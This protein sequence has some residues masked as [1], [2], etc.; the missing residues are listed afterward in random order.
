MLFEKSKNII[1]VN[2]I[3]HTRDFVRSMEAMVV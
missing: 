2:N 1:N 3:I